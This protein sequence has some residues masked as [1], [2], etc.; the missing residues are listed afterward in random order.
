M[1]EK[2]CSCDKTHSNTARMTIEMRGRSGDDNNNHDKQT[3]EE[4]EKKLMTKTIINEE[5]LSMLS[6]NEKQTK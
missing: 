2:K 4:E 3:K 1:R 5:C 6:E